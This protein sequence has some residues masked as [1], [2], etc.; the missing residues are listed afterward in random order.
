L[1]SCVFEIQHTQYN[2][3]HIPVLAKPIWNF[4]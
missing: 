2:S 1:H 3:D 4:T